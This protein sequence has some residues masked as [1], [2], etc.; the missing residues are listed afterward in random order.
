MGNGRWMTA[1][2][3]PYLGLARLS[4]SDPY[5]AVHSTG[6]T[7]RYRRDEEG[8]VSLFPRISTA[9]DETRSRVMVEVF[10]RSKSVSCRVFRVA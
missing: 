8:A 9:R 1:E 4:L 3:R 7:D 10:R 5:H 6:Q 2:F